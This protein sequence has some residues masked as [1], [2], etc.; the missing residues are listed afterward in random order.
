MKKITTLLIL[1]LTLNSFSQAIVTCTNDSIKLKTKNY[2][3]GNIEWE[4]ST[5]GT[6]W[7]K[8]ENQF[9][10]TYVFRP[11]ITS[12]YRAVNK[13]PN[14]SPIYSSETLTL[15]PPVANAGSD[16]LINDKFIYLSGNSEAK[17]TGSWTLLE[18]ENGTFEDT[19]DS[20]TKFTGESGAYKL[21]W[22]L[23]N[24]CGFSTDTVSI[25]IPENTYYDKIVIVDETDKILSTDEEI[26]NG[27]YK[28][29]FSDPV[30]EISSESILIGIGGEGFLRKVNSVNNTGN[31]FTI[32][33]SQGKLED[34]LLDGGL[35]LSK[36]LNLDTNTTSNK[37]S[38]YQQLDKLPTRKEILSNEKFKTG[39]HYYIIDKNVKSLNN[40]VKLKKNEEKGKKVL[41]FVIGDEKDLINEEGLRINLKGEVTFTPNF[42]SE[43]K[44]AGNEVRLGMDKAKLKNQFTFTL[45]GESEK[46]ILNKKLSLFTYYENI[47]FLIAGI[48]VTITS[49]VD[50]ESKADAKIEG[51]F[52]FKHQ[53]TNTV[54]ANAG[55]SYKNNEWS[56]YYNSFS[57]NELDNSIEIKGGFL[58]NFEIG[59]KISFKIYGL[60]GPFID[61]KLTEKFSLCAKSQNLGNYN[62]NGNLDLGAKISVGIEAVKWLNVPPLIKNFPTESLYKLQFPYKLNYFLG[63][64]QQYIKGEPLA[65]MPEVRITNNKGKP[66]QFVTVRFEKEINSIDIISEEYVLTDIDGFART[67]WTP[68]SDNSSKLRVSVVDCEDKNISNSPYIFTATELQTTDCSETTLSA[69]YKVDNNFL[70]PVAHRGVAPYIYSTDNIDFSPEKPTITIIEGNTYTV[71]IKDANGC[72][73][74]KSYISKPFTCDDSDL[75]FEIS[76]YGNNLDVTGFGGTPPYEYSIDDGA[77][78]T[79]NYTF[80]DLENQEYNI[81]IKDANGCEKSSTIDLKNFNTELV[82][83]FDYENDNGLVTFKNLSNGADSYEWNF[84][85]GDSA[86]IQNPK[87]SFKSTGSFKVT[88]TSKN[89]DDISKSYFINININEFINP[90]EE[91]LDYY[92]NQ[93]V[94]FETENN[95][96]NPTFSLNG[97]NMYGVI[98]SKVVRYKLDNKYNFNNILGHFE[99]LTTSENGRSK[100]AKEVVINSNGTKLFV[101]VSYISLGSDL[102]LQYNLPTPYS[103][104]N[105][106]LVDQFEV[107][108][109]YAGLQIASDDKTIYLM[110]NKGQSIIGYRFKNLELISSLE[111]DSD[112]T[113]PTIGAPY[114]MPYI[115]SKSGNSFLYNRI[116]NQTN[117]RKL[118]RYLVPE[119][120]KL[121]PLK[122]LFLAVEIESEIIFDNINKIIHY[123]DDDDKIMFFSATEDNKFKLYKY[124]I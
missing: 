10:T 72:I 90:D 91:S 27:N 119:K 3:F 71:Y 81:I 51:S 9:D 59:P 78:F 39:V 36:M 32:A 53:F 5:D 65:N 83:Y 94:V 60:A 67:N 74:S 7:E 66:V 89:S 117:F 56:G 118:E 99:E 12:Y 47:F 61:L 55:V 22:R 80:Y 58:Q 87:H 24:S 15:R 98:D 1:I 2:K 34:I 50:F 123:Y 105:A 57:T 103:L 68:I 40:N 23:E 115:I 17:S 110:S 21:I 69:S 18:G 114:K 44:L 111:I 43:Y 112:Y 92:T 45:V 29:E 113:L 75:G 97:L 102:I 33:T 120:W 42:F 95:L 63:N 28:I 70:T 77:T 37:T 49:I 38:G 100:L 30:P 101:K 82:A 86:N 62:W 54:T 85:D 88:L 79:N 26:E 16:R 108:Y 124:K 104:I 25:Q 41:N 48:P 106:E 6:N 20:A 64:N 109:A 107:F 96:S 13:L 46:E 4:K 122:Y 116:P 73:A 31:T 8:I 14:C 121:K 52:T 84:G 35:E 19:S 93:G 11:L 76:T